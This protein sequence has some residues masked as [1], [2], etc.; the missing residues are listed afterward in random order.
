[1]VKYEIAMQLKTSHI[2]THPINLVKIN[3]CYATKDFN[4]GQL[5][6]NHK[7]LAC[8]TVC[9]IMRCTCMETSECKE[10][11]FKKRHRRRRPCEKAPYYETEIWEPVPLLI[12]LINET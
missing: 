10:R 4:N 3:F 5:N 7:L 2:I 6:A 1:M 12:N 11:S 9:T 8:V